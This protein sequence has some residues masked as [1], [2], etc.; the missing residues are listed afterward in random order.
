[1]SVGASFFFRNPL[2]FPDIYP[3][4][5]V[6]E[7]SSVGGNPILFNIEG[8]RIEP[9]VRVNPDVTG[10]DAGNTTFFIPG[11]LIGFEIPGT[12]EPD[13]FPQFTGT[14]AAA[15]HV[16]AV[17]ALMNEAAGERLAPDRITEVLHQT[18]TDLDDQKPKAFDER[19][20]LQN[21]LWLRRRTRSG[22]H[23]V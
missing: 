12:T 15:P 6:N 22:R 21:R 3:L 19:L 16:A 8:S 9:D 1:M 7:Y 4:P 23:R 13:E 5:E 2:Y 10:P 20:R 17:A 14:S 18:A 11:L